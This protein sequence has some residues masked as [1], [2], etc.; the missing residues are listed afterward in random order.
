M[1]TNSLWIVVGFLGQLLFG[2]R[3]IIQW[4]V[5]ERQKRSVV[6]I[7]FW[8]LSL[9]GTALLFSY[10]VAKHDPVFIVGQAA[11]AVVYVRNLNL[12]RHE[13]NAGVKPP[14]PSEA[15]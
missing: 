13:R 7:A 5:S 2:A 4:I 9:G 3:F 15:Q 1:T 8:Y 14:T 11:G 6:P 12:I 10:A